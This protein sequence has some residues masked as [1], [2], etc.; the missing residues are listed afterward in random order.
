MRDVGSLHEQE[1]HECP[2]VV[3][4]APGV[5]NLMGAHTEAT[6][7]YLLVFGMDKR[8]Y[9]AASRRDDGSMRFYAADLDERKRTSSSALKYRREDR[10]AG[11][12]KGVISRLQ[13]LGAHIGGLNV[14]VTSDIPAGIGLGA[15]QAIGVATVA[16]FADAFAH[17][18]RKIE[19]QTAATGEDRASAI[20]K[21]DS[22]RVPAPIAPDVLI[23]AEQLL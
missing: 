19:I 7:G 10:F 2:Q 11:L 17:L 23:R 4:T 6:D 22:L 3:A 13:T 18:A 16:D 8:A 12:C 15:S 21:F 5:V 9:V 1:Y 14:T 20:Q